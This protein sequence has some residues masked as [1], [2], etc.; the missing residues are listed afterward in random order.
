MRTAAQPV[1]PLHVIER[2]VPST[3][4]RKL[5]VRHQLERKRR[6]A[7]LRRGLGAEHRAVAVHAAE[8]AA[9]EQVVIV[10]HEVSHLPPAFRHPEHPGDGA[11]VALALLL[12]ERA[13][14][15][16]LAREPRQEPARRARQVG[17]RG[18]RAGAP[19]AG[20]HRAGERHDGRRARRAFQAPSP[21]AV[22]PR[23]RRTPDG[24]RV[25]PGRGVDVVPPTSVLIRG[26]Q[27]ADGLAAGRRRGAVR[28]GAGGGVAEE[29]ER[30]RASPAA[31][32]PHRLLAHDGGYPILCEWRFS[33]GGGVGHAAHRRGFVLR[34][35]TER[36][37]EWVERSVQRGRD[38]SIRARRGVPLATV[39]GLSNTS[40]GGGSSIFTID[41]EIFLTASP[42]EHSIGAFWEWV[43]GTAHSPSWSRRFARSS[44]R[45]WP[46]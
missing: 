35:A 30:S 40:R 31:L 17:I 43:R 36:G 9:P 24:R 3:P 38:R 6:L 46:G 15:R 8:P 11:E 45:Q 14:Q 39:V 7:L 22:H 27:I 20:A 26:G 4:Q 34:V 18:L 42:C 10:Q 5:R 28:A 37:Q 1:Q 13:L 32:P 16:G 25:I 41:T 33:P 12:L 29:H 21:A 2:I 23:R 19:A 44:R